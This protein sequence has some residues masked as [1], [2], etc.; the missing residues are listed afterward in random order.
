[1]HPTSHLKPGHGAHAL[2]WALVSSRAVLIILYICTSLVQDQNSAWASPPADLAPS[3]KDL[4]IVVAAVM[5]WTAADMGLPVLDELPRLVFVEP[6]ELLN[7]LTT[8]RQRVEAAPA[9]SAGTAQIEAFYNSR[10][11]TLY[12]PAGWTGS[13]P[14]ELSVLVHE[15]VHHLQ[16]L[17]SQQFDCPADREKQAFAS[18]A[19]WLQ[20][21]GE[22]LEGAFGI[23]GFTLLVRTKCA[24]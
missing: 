19:R 14:T 11:R 23:D 2:S 1:M 24:F 20:M 12:M 8:Q 22:D 5:G 4:K 9:A 3:S 18:Q 10:T 6:H 21:F 7:E 13:S 17:S 15:L 16:T